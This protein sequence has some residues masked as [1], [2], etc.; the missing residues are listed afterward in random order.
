[1]FLKRTYCTEQGIYAMLY[2]NY[3]WSLT[4]KSCES[5]CCTF[6]TYN[7]VY[8]LHLTNK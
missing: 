2:D 4:F 6:E 1:M 3:K 8:K 5:L 7:I